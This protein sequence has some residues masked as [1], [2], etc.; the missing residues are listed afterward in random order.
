MH[1]VRLATLALS[2]L[3]GMGLLAAC[4]RGTPARRRAG[5][6]HHE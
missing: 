1:Q 3:I 5:H 4:G 6:P 2:G